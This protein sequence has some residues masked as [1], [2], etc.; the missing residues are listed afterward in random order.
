[1][2]KLYT[3]LRVILRATMGDA[4]TM[5]M[6]DTITSI[7]ARAIWHNVLAFCLKKRRRDFNTVI[8]LREEEKPA[9]W[10]RGMVWNALSLV[11]R[12]GKRFDETGRAEWLR[13]KGISLAGA[14]TSVIFAA[15]KVLLRQT[16]VCCDKIRL[17]V[18]IKLCLSRNKYVCRNT[19]K[20]MLVETKRVCRNKYLRNRIGNR[21][22]SP[23]IRS[24]S[25]D[26]N[27]N[28]RH[29]RNRGQRLATSTTNM[30]RQQ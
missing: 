12:Q 29:H 17:F 23:S 4:V 7:L 10:L 24:S 9:S 3:V 1:M 5:K 20:S 14:A 8:C 18:A 22:R 13:H 19:R 11:G 6:V 27:D 16:R 26:N 25:D 15:T 21:I 28:N 30:R 2:K